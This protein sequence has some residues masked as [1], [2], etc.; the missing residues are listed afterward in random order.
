M[1]VLQ[2]MQG[3]SVGKCVKVQE[4]KWNVISVKGTSVVKGYMEGIGAGEIY[5]SSDNE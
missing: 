5:S 2:H 3:N 1:K 4:G